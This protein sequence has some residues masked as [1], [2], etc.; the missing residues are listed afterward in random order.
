MAHC[1]DPPRGETLISP[2]GEAEPPHFPR[3]KIAMRLFVMA[4]A[5]RARCVIYAPG[6]LFP[7][8]DE[9]PHDET[10]AKKTQE[11]CL[12]LDCKSGA[13]DV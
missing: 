9:R 8:H 1:D 10:K 4:V 12:A 13:V 7:R 5:A 3:L 11:C 6:S 2:E